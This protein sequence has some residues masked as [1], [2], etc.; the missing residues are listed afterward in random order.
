MDCDRSEVSM[1]SHSMGVWEAEELH[2]DWQ[3]KDKNVCGMFGNT[4]PCLL[5]K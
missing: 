1:K 3:R 5:Y 4:Q 2:T